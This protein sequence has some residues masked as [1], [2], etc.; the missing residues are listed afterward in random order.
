MDAPERCTKCSSPLQVVELE[1]NKTSLGSLLTGAGN[2]R[3]RMRQNHEK[4]ATILKELERVKGWYCSECQQVSF[5]V[6][7]DTNIDWM[8]L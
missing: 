5:H 8:N 1:I 6:I 2:S 4:W 7:P 3:L